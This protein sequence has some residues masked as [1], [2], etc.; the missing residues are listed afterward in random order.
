[1]TW[2][3]STLK[4]VQFTVHALVEYSS[5][6]IY[7][8]DRG[9]QSDEL[10]TVV[11]QVEMEFELEPQLKVKIEEQLLKLVSHEPDST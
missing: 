10:G 3:Y 11:R 9:F 5:L 6:W 1:M 4:E 2:S 8:K 7:S